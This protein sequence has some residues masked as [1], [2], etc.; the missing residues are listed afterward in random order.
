M[1]QDNWGLLT[2]SSATRVNISD[3]LP[4]KYL[5]HSTYAQFGMMRL[6]IVWHFWSSPLYCV[7]NCF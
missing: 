7:G 1:L 4:L 3:S 6:S 2:R 5:Q